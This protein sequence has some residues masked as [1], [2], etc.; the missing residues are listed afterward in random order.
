MR[1]ALDQGI[2]ILQQDRGINIDITNYSLLL[3]D[4]KP[5]FFRQFLG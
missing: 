4:I 5:S 1:E 2:I 3:V